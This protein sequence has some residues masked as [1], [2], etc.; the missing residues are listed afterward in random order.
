MFQSVGND[1][2]ARTL[3]NKLEVRTE[4]GSHVSNKPSA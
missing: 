3:L 2:I 1:K 4:R